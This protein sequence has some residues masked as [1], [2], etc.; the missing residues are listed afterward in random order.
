MPTGAP[1]DS[2]GIREG[3]VAFKL[4]REAFKPSPILMGRRQEQFLTVQDRWILLRGKLAHLHT[5]SVEVDQPRPMQDW[6]RLLEEAWIVQQSHLRSVNS[7]PDDA[8][9][10]GLRHP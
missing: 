5:S 9:D 10:V 6:E 3:M 2:V 4:V 8:V 1:T 7:E